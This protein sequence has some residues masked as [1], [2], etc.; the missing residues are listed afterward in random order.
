M[1][2]NSI[3]Y[4]FMNSVNLMNCRGDCCNYSAKCMASPLTLAFLI[5][6]IKL[7]PFADR[8]NPDFCSCLVRNVVNVSTNSFST[9][10]LFRR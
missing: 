4:S 1:L 9:G 5:I 3:A 7:F 10:L 8:T 2:G 6:F